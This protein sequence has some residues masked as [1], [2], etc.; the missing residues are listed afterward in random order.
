MAVPS[1]YQQSMRTTSLK[2]TPRGS[3]KVAQQAVFSILLSLSF[4][5][6]LNDAM[7]SLIP[8]I[9]PLIKKNYHLTFAQIGLITLTYQMVASLLQPLVGSFTDRRPQPYSLAIGMCFT[10]GGLLCLSL[11][12]SFE[13]V[14]FSVGLVGMGSAVFHPESSRMAHLA[15]GGRRGMAQSV[16]QVGGNTGSAIGPLLAAAIIVPLGQSY[17]AVFSLLAL[18]GIFVLWRVGKWYKKNFFYVKKERADAPIIKAPVSHKKTIMS[19][20]ILL[21]LVFSKYFYLA[22]MTSYYTFYLI[23]KF[24]V[25]VQS[26]QVYL[27]IFLFAVAAGTMIGG[28]LGDRFGRKYVIWF[29]I[30]GVSPFTL[31]LPYMSLLWTAVLSVVIGVI[32]TSAFSAI[33]VY[34]QELVPGKVGMISGL[35]YGLAFGMGGIGSAVLGELA[36]S[37]SIFYVYHVCSFLPLIGLLAA[38]LP[39]IEGKRFRR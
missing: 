7:Q 19:L 31:L 39:N 15:S 12:G 38:F 17:V 20:G 2:D 21:S 10:L 3:K 28:P 13:A 32:L 30:L 27:F 5:H 36:D 26:S 18:V 35:F 11:A 22:S 29:S 16:F 14:L 6:F 23:G 24:H 33:I 4:A 34:A 37:T 9:Y 1:G 25:S 8:S